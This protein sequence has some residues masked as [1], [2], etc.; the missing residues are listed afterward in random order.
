MIPTPS[1]TG[2]LPTGSGR[3][4]LGLACLG[5]G[6]AIYLAVAGRALGPSDF[7]AVALFWTVL[8]TVGLGF[9]VPLE[10]EV[11]R[12]SAVEVASGRPARTA[13]GGGYVLWC[14]A[15]FAAV[16]VVLGI[17]GGTE[18]LGGP[19]S[20]VLVLA[21]LGAMALAY[22]ARGVLAGTAQWGRYGA[23]LALDGVLRMA[24]GVLVAATAP[25]SPS[26]FMSVVVISTVAAAVLTRPR[27]VPRGTALVGG[28]RLGPPY[29]WLVAASLCS[30]VI[31]NGAPAA[32]ETLVEKHD[33]ATGQFL[34]ALVIAR[35]PLFLFAAVSAALLAAL[36]TCV[37]RG[38][39]AG[40]RRTTAALLRLVVAVGAAGVGAVA[41]VGQQ[42]LEVA[43]GSAFAVERHVLVLL[44]GSTA[45]LMAVSVL[46]TALIAVRLHRSAALGT[47]LGAVVLV[48]GAIAARP[49][50]TGSIALALFVGSLT[51][52]TAL[53]TLLVP[54]TREP[55][56]V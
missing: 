46:T 21:G 40:F 12:T 3:V 9:F 19:A 28:G 33:A 16:T 5:A 15:A 13:A 49:A 42:F 54:A 6:S 23:Q 29:A 36:S 30:M 22:A 25:G 18:P 50:T 31:T 20:A 39:R 53:G 8:H 45:A 14:L 24:L 41:L 32:V 1:A 55:R 11:T 27:A 7:A 52:V 26:A 43:F 35:L 47:A 17:G 34:A 48:L 2:R 38:D 37:Q 44:A 10:Q 4:G 56:R 51:A